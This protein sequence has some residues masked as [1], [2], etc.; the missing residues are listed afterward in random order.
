MQDTEFNS[1]EPVGFIP[2]D[3]AAPTS[4]NGIGLCLFGGVVALED[5]TR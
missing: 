3:G 4:R 2:S 5:V 1:V